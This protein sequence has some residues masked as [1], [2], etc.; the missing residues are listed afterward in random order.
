MCGVFATVGKEPIP[1]L[2]Q[3]LHRAA[4]AMVHRGP[5][6][7]GTWI[8]PD[9]A[10]GLAHRR[11]AVMAPAS[12]QQPIVNER[13]N[14]IAV[15]NG[16]FYGSAEI[17]TELEGLGHVFSTDSDSE[18]LVH[19]YEQHGLDCLAQLRGEFAFV[20]WDEEKRRLFA[21]RDRF[22]VKPLLYCLRDQTMMLASEAKA[23]FAAGVPAQWNS[24]AFHFAASIQYLPPHQ[25]LFSG[26]EMLPPGHLLIWARGEVATSNYWDIPEPTTISTTRPEGLV[27]ECRHQIQDAIQH[28]L[29]ADAPICF[30]LSGGLDSSSVAGIAAESSTDPINV[31]SICFPESSYSEFDV[32][33]RTATS[34]SARF[35]PVEVTQQQLLQKLPEAVLASEGLSINGHVA[36]KYIMHQRMHEAGFKVV[37]TGEGADEAFFGYTHLRMD[38][39]EQTGQPFPQELVASNQT[40]KGMMLPDGDSLSTDR[41]RYTA[42]TV[43]AW[44]AAKAT[45]G[46]K[47]H[48]LLR[49]EFRSE[50]GDDAIY[51]VGRRYLRPQTTTS[52][53]R[54]AWTRVAT[55]GYILKTLGDGTEMPHSM[56]G[57]VPF[58]DHKLWEFLAKVP[59]SHLISR[60][61]DKPLLRDSVRPF[62]TN[63]VFS[64]PKH[65]F[66]APPLSV[67]SGEAGREFVNDHVRSEA[68]RQQPFFSPKK[69]EQQ[70]RRLDAE[71]A[72][73]QVWDPPLM[74]FLS[75]VL[76]QQLIRT[77][78]PAN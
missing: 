72:L 1:D 21:A 64:R 10:V 52:T 67:F 18:I 22:G 16:E 78:V 77:P 38:H 68:A 74:L 75:T 25:T 40:S 73:R 7:S 34:L 26:I 4:D 31:F 5:D 65:P 45:M 41:L 23:L 47:T 54:D 33:S 29:T 50:I 53:S 39:W 70:L 36:A 28:R 13:G 46:W 76:L 11:L 59:L 62:I 32:A 63:E 56:E 69:V 2:R 24:L 57:R 19:L 14:V 20:L 17:R 66:D 37:L 12:G 15:V 60:Q 51:Q 27:D 49:N 55:A 9:R 8:S 35:H 71:P 42:S 30:Q 44:I 3:K 61:R 6:G 58:L 43:P 48:R